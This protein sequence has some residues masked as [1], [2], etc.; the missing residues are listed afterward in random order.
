MDYCIRIENPYSNLRQIANLP[1]LRDFSKSPQR[2]VIC[3]TLRKSTSR[4]NGSNVFFREQSR[5]CSSYA[6]MQ[7]RLVETRYKPNAQCRDYQQ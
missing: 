7:Q 2:G 5:T 6:E 1:Q 3:V 4:P